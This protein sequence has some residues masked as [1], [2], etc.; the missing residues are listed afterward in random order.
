MPEETNDLK[1]LK[2]AHALLLSIYRE[3]DLEKT[4]KA[5]LEKWGASPDDFGNILN[6]LGLESLPVTNGKDW[7]NVTP[8]TTNLDIGKGQSD[9][10][11]QTFSKQ[12]QRLEYPLNHSESSRPTNIA[13]EAEQYTKDIDKI[14]ANSDGP[15]VKDNLFALLKKYG[16]FISS[17]PISESGEIPYCDYFHQHLAHYVTGENKE[18][19]LYKGDISGIQKFI[20]RDINK[21][22]NKAKKLR[23]RSNYLSLLTQTIL[24]LLRKEFGL[25][26]YSVLMNSGGHFMLLIP[27]DQELK[28]KLSDFEQDLQE[29]LFRTY[30]GD[31]VLVTAQIST[32]PEELIQNYGKEISRLESNLQLAKKQKGKSVAHQIFGPGEL[33]FEPEHSP[34]EPSGEHHFA[35]DEDCTILGEKLPKTDQ[36]IA[37][38]DNDES[39]NKPANANVKTISIHNVH[40]LIGPTNA[41]ME[42]AQ[43]LSGLPHIELISRNST[44]LPAKLNL[45]SQS[46]SWN[47][48]FTGDYAPLFTEE[49]ISKLKKMSTIRSEISPSVGDVIPFDILGMLS[50]EPYP[51]LA[52]LRLDVD[53]LGAIFSY[54]LPDDQQNHLAR[55]L[56]LSRSFDHFFGGHI[57]LLAEEHDIYLTYS[58]GDDVFAVGDWTHIMEFAFNL[59]EDFKAFADNNPNL[60][61]S[62]G[63]IL[64]KSHFPI[65]RA[66]AEAGEAE[67]KAK[68][69]NAYDKNCIHLFSETAGWQHAQEHYAFGRKLFQVL[70]EENEELTLHGQ[71]LK[72]PASMVH[73]LLGITKSVLKRNGQVNMEKLR[74]LEPRLKYTFAR[75]GLNDKVD[76]EL[77]AKIAES[78]AKTSKE[79][80]VEKIS[81]WFLRYEKNDLKEHWRHFGISAQT[82]IY[83]KRQNSNN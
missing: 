14:I 61:F 48:L 58:G 51:M 26:A 79:E 4:T 34:E 43:Q 29:Y 17:Q 16:S 81:D 9:T 62:A 35:Y 53:N 73:Q 22:D 71:K 40:W 59:R 38:L 66:A 44:D 52:T 24:L 67:E 64:H 2:F 6:D 31:L 54:G 46:L 42:S 33:L 41:L 82:A 60:T 49:K 76:K 39:F 74:R 8:V 78:H 15:I 30:H 7:P 47:Y 27:R 5:L 19:V 32:N 1:L 25:P 77:R 80:I 63:L 18:T 21:V 28:K 36:M 13:D 50:S 10:K 20:Y 57:N 3:S 45:G 68:Q 12:L 83:L 72:F 56:S 11:D 55:I 37:A 69:S 23:G 75:R 65:N 70:S